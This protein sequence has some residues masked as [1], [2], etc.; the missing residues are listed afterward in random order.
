MKNTLIRLWDKSQSWSREVPCYHTREFQLETISYSKG[1]IPH[2][3][4]HM[5]FPQQI[6]V[7]LDGCPSKY[8]LKSTALLCG[9]HQDL[10]FVSWFSSME[11]S[12]EVGYSA[13][14][15][16]SDWLC[17]LGWCTRYVTKASLGI[18]K[19]AGRVAPQFSMG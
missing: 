17:K 16:H 11:L 13:H 18:G 9:L 15:P 19:N 3:L 10:C 12:L 7:F 6:Y 14:G 4:C 1:N 8:Q 5:S 2:R